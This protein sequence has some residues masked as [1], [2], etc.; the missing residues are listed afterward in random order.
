MAQPEIEAMYVHA[1]PYHSVMYW[2]NG[3]PNKKNRATVIGQRDARLRPE[4][5][6][7]GWHVTPAGKVYRLYSELAWSGELIEFKGGDKQSYWIVKSPG[8]NLTATLL[9]DSAK[10]TRRRITLS[11][12]ELTLTAPPRSIVC[13]DQNG[14]EIAK[15][16]L[17]Y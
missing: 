5:L 2:S 7:R 13:F 8:G 17:P 3:K 12:R 14:L 11:G 4:Q 1:V 6:T 10:E 9:N 15:L 16:A